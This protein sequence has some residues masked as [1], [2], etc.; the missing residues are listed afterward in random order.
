MSDN[1]TMQAS[2]RL[3]VNVMKAF[4][5]ALALKD[6]TSQQVIENAIREFIKSADLEIKEEY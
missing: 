1:K 5:I 4:R 6:T 3:P 2:A